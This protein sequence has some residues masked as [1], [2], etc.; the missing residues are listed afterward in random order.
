VSDTA[1]IRVSFRHSTTP[2]ETQDYPGEYPKSLFNDETFTSECATF[3]ASLADMQPN[4]Q[5]PSGDSSIFFQNYLK[6][7]CKP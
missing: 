4:A 2:R 6:R 3:G 7:G 5:D 1:D